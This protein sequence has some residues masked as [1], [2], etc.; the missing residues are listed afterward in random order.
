MKQE[1]PHNAPLK[2]ILSGGG[3]GGHLFPALAVANS[4]KERHDQADLLF[5]GAKGKMEMEKVPKAGYP[6]KGL[7]IS[8][9]QRG[10]L[11][12]NLLLPFKIVSALFRSWLILKKFRPQVAIG[13]GG[14]ASAPL[15][16]V[17]AKMGIPTLIQEQN[18]FPGITNKFLGKYVDRVCVVYENMEQYFPAHKMVVTG[19]P[20]RSDLNQ[21]SQSVNEARKA[22][23]LNPDQPTIL[24]TGGSLG[25]RSL[26][27]GMLNAANALKHKGIQAIWQTGQLYHEE[28]TSRLDDAY[29][30][31]LQLQPFIEDMA[32]AYK[33][34]DL[35]VCRAG[36]ITLAEL[37]LLG[38]PAILVPS[39]NVAEDHQTKNALALVE[40]DAAKMLQDQELESHLSR[41]IVDL[42][43]H[44]E[45]LEKLS[46]NVKQFARP[47]ATT[48]IVEEAE[49]LIKKNVD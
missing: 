21:V 11:F 31:G 43:D 30:V 20:V 16:Y 19:N 36:A 17:A 38:K 10:Q 39:P 8:G 1:N 48:S 2:A 34:A 4:L 32:L 22:F 44:P 15:L 26:N 7:W 35:V 27:E 12:S 41:T 23:N 9:Y 18:F 3:T 29:K 25:A 49:K 45:T 14:Y 37:A 47:K 46:A 24:V 42:V 28:M 33:A 5:V 13:T 40:Q 6:I